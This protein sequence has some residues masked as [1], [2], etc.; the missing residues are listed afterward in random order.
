VRAATRSPADL[1]ARVRAGDRRAIGRAISLCENGEPEAAPLVEEL[2]PL[3]GRAITVGLTGP[4]GVGKSTLVGA[5]VGHLRAAGRSVGVVAVDPSSPF[6]RGALLGDRIRM[7]DHFLDPEVFIRSM[8]TRGHLGGVAEATFL[9]MVVLDAAGKDVVLVETVG[10]GQSEV[11][12]RSLVDVVSLVLQPGSGDSIQAIKA[13]LM[14]IPDVI[15]LNKRDHSS[16]PAARRELHHALALGDKDS[17]PAVVESD[18]VRG[19]GIGELWDEL[20]A[21]RDALGDEGLVHRRRA[22]LARELVTIASARSSTRLA[23]LISDEV[24]NRLLDRLDAGEVDPVRAV[25]EL[26]AAA[27]DDG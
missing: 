4:P 20:M 23:A 13:G 9:A 22:N 1:A 25:A 21:R 14:E 26:Q 18:A 10:V 19:E 8:G 16:A 2:W 15:C 3:A 5:L 24:G 17:R 11:E 12:V 6:T 27:R 7:S